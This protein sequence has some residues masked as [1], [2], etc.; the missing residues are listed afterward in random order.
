MGLVSIMDHVIAVAVSRRCLTAAPRFH[1]QVRP[2]NICGRQGTGLGFL[3]TLR[4]PLPILI[5]P[6]A[7]Q[8]CLIWSW[9]YRPTSGRCNVTDC[10]TPHDEIK[11]NS[12]YCSH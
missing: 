8:T 7:Q 11:N 12:Q 3:Q 9:Y 4:F 2:C 10:V 5:Q 1:S 6:S